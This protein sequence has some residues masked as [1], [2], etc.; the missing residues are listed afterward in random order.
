MVAGGIW[1]DL[2]TSRWE[3]QGSVREPNANWVSQSPL[4]SSKFA[5]LADAV[6]V[7]LHLFL[8]RLAEALDAKNVEILHGEKSVMGIQIG[9]NL[10]SHNLVQNA[11]FGFTSV[12]QI[13]WTSASAQLREE[14]PKARKGLRHFE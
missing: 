14:E 8:P 1:G 12:D 7:P 9:K 10:E 3:G 5:D 13:L 4:S 6:L 11:P 2:S